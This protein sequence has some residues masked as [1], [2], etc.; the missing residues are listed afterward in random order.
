MIRHEPCTIP[1]GTPK[2]MASISEVRPQIGASR[3][4]DAKSSK[5][6]FQS[7]GRFPRY[8]AN[9]IAVNWQQD[10]PAKL[11]AL[12][13]GALPV[14]MGR[15]YGDSCLLNG[16]SLMVMTGMDRMLAFDQAT[17]LVTAEAGLTLGQ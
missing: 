2:T 1:A 7:W 8:Q 11:S 12:R 5:E 13:H 14:G 10:I 6:I 17:G 16:R 4:V 9:L 3:T 15:S